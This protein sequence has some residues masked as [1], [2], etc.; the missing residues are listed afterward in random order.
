MSSVGCGVLQVMQE[1]QEKYGRGSVVK[2]IINEAKKVSSYHYL[3]VL[4]HDFT[5]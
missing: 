2:D 5:L 3:L 1:F 4:T